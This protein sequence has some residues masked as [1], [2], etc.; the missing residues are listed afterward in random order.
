MMDRTGAGLASRFVLRPGGRLGRMGICASLVRGG[1]VSGGEV[2]VE[3]EF[4]GLMVTNRGVFH[5]RVWFLGVFEA[6]AVCAY[7]FE[8][9][10]CGGGG[11][12]VDGGEAAGFIFRHFET[13]LRF[14]W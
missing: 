8:G 3:M 13:R 14:W 9:W 12:E 6:A 4:G 1:G 11:E 2:S 10:C 5:G 7:W